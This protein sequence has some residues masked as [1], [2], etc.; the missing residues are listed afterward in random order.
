MK[1]LFSLVYD[2]L[3][4]PLLKKSREVIVVSTNTQDKCTCLP[5]P[6]LHNL[7]DDDDDDI[8]CMSMHDRYAARP[9]KPMSVDMMCLADFASKYKLGRV[10]CTSSQYQSGSTSEHD[11]DTDTTFPMKIALFEK[12]GVMQMRRNSAVVHTHF[13]DIET[14][15]NIYMVNYFFFSPGIVKMNASMFAVMT[16]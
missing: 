3:S 16:H 11:S 14:E 13:C 1:Y 12:K 5:K 9:L 7:Q 2:L 15:K 6:K 4:M 8:F 10:N